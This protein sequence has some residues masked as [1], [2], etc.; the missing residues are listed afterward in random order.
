MDESDGEMRFRCNFVAGFL[1]Q[2]E[3]RTTLRRHYN[4]ATA[5]LN[6]Y[7]PCVEEVKT[8]DI[9]GTEAV[10]KLRASGPGLGTGNALLALAAEIAKLRIGGGQA[11]APPIA[12]PPLSGSGGSGSGTSAALVSGSSPAVVSLPPSPSPPPILP[13]PG[14]NNPHAQPQP[15]P[16]PLPPQPV[17]HAGM[18]ARPSSAHPG[19]PGG[20]VPP[21]NGY[22]PQHGYPT[23]PMPPNGHLP[24]SG[25]P[26]P[27]MHNPHAPV[28][29]AYPTGGYPPHGGHHHPG[30]PNH[31]H[32]GHA[33]H[34]SHGGGGFPPNPH[35]VSSTPTPYPAAHPHPHPHYPTG[36]YP[37]YQ[38]HPHHYPP[39]STPPNPAFGTPAAAGGVAPPVAHHH[40]NHP[41]WG[42][43]GSSP[44]PSVGSQPGPLPH[45]AVAPPVAAVSLPLPNVGGLSAADAKSAVTLKLADIHVQW[46]QPRAYRLGKG[47]MGEVWAG[48]WQQHTDVAVK[49]VS[50]A[51]IGD[52]D[53]QKQLFL[54]EMQINSTMRH[55]N[56]VQFIGVAYDDHNERWL[57]VTELCRYKSLAD[58]LK[59]PAMRPYLP[60]SVRKRMLREAALGLHYLHCERIIHMV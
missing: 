60:W 14:S 40:Q 44:P 18:P 42:R 22:A 13:A 15:V 59:E 17:A 23:G 51:C 7:Y 52:R 12:N 39:S 6:R 11:A 2:S 35:A 56:V 3:F 58:V 32:P 46:D 16:T 55:P 1:N 53:D 31:Q 25:Y 38:P 20:G 5:T 4:A 8:T 37:G 21:P 10:R 49:V 45:A 24:H 50:S 28:A 36:T 41:S 19:H 34:A 9:S 33:H 48:K 57:L 29:A 26:P 47:G 27:N 54:R 43:P 30:Y